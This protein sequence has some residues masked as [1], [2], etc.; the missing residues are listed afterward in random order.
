MKSI[1]ELNANLENTTGQLSSL[2]QKDA[3][4]KRKLEK[5]KREITNLQMQ[6][7]SLNAQLNAKEEI[8]TTL[9]QQL[10]LA[11]LHTH[12]ENSIRRQDNICKEVLYIPVEKTKERA[13][14]K[15]KE[16][17]KESRK[18]YED[19]KQT[20]SLYKKVKQ[21]PY[22]EDAKSL[23]NKLSALGLQKQRVSL[24]HNNS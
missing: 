19:H 13:K 2:E 20:D 24:L 12:H 6:V 4:N 14:E 18:C 22:E 11:L 9:Q 8:I 7:N 3:H 5:A 10:N 16:T 1:E 23:E 21:E 17:P 15:A